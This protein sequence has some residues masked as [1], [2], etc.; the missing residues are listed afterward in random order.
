VTLEIK[1]TLLHMSK[2]ELVRSHCLQLFA[3]NLLFNKKLFI[4]MRLQPHN[5]DQT[6]LAQLFTD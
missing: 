4:D 1:E 5:K 6:W 3:A 2:P